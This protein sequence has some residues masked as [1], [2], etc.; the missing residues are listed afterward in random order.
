[1]YFFA[2]RLKRRWPYCGSV[3]ECRCRSH[4]RESSLVQVP[5]G[6]H[7]SS[8]ETCSLPRCVA[9]IFVKAPRRNRSYIQ[10]IGNKSNAEQALPAS[11]GCLPD[12]TAHTVKQELR[13]YVT[14]C[15]K[16][17]EGFGS[18]AQPPCVVVDPRRARPSSRRAHKRRTW[19]AVVRTLGARRSHHRLGSLRTTLRL[20]SA[21]REK[22]G[23]R[24]R[25]PTRNRLPASALTAQVSLRGSLSLMLHLTSPLQGS[26]PKQPQV[27][28]V[29][30]RFKG[31]GIFLEFSE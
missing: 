18:I 29:P 28:R 14:E 2:V 24:Y 19:P 4:V 27:V 3:A 17:P 7:S 30:G 20:N 13:N 8:H 15:P 12:A 16:S 11:A 10:E 31:T 22:D 6:S 9:M 21:L 5:G 26:G 25:A 1:M 23:S